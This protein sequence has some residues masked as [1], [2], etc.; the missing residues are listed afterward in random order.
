MGLSQAEK[1]QLARLLNQVEENVNGDW[2]LV[3]KGGIRGI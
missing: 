1:E 2:E 3:K